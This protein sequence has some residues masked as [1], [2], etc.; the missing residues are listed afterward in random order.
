M[1]KICS[2]LLALVCIVCLCGAGAPVNPFN[3]TG[4]NMIVSFPDDYVIFGQKG[5]MTDNAAAAG[6]NQEMIN[7]GIAGMQELGTLL[8]AIQ[9]DGYDHILVDSNFFEGTRNM[10]DFTKFCRES[11]KSDAELLASL[12]EMTVFREREKEIEDSVNDTMEIVTV[13]GEKYGYAVGHFDSGDG[14]GNQYLQEYVT[15]KNGRYI[16]FDMVINGEPHA[17][18]VQTLRDI[19]QSIAYTRGAD[20]FLSEAFGTVNG[21]ALIPWIVLG[22]AVIVGIVVLVVLL[23]IRRKKHPKPKKGTPQGEP[24]PQGGP[25]TPPAPQNPGQPYMTR[26]PYQ[27]GPRPQDAPPPSQ[28]QPGA[29]QNAGNTQQGAYTP[30]VVQ[31][32][33]SQPPVTPPQQPVSEQ[34]A[35][36]EPVVSA[37]P[38]RTEPVQTAPFYGQGT[39]PPQQPVA[40]PGQPTPQTPPTSPG[41]TDIVALM[42]NLAELKR[43]GILSPEEYEYKKSELLRRL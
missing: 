16:R 34:P 8:M 1:K 37:Q 13:N 5:P 15:V 18:Q 31:R 39:V 23:R 32:S 35:P 2:L 25:Y 10:Q 40:Q 12:E 41:Q 38:P 14:F 33:E 29:P 28:W 42:E 11:G 21:A 3:V 22:V 36:Q 24:F 20:S 19:I 43:Q 4:T 26:Q 17:D 30:P 7:T 9:L 6:L 27:A